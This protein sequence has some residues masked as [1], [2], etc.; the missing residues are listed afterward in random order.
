VNAIADAYLASGSPTYETDRDV[1]L[2]RLSGGGSGYTSSN[3]GANF[4]NDDGNFGPPFTDPL[5]S[6]AT[7]A[8]L[9]QGAAKSQEHEQRDR[10]RGDER[11]GRLHEQ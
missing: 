8:L 1:V 2:G 9:F 10:L 4:N 11:S 3:R 7:E 5:P 6:T